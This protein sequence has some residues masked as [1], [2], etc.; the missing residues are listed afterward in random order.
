MYKGYEIKYTDPGFWQIFSFRFLSG[1]PFTPGGLRFWYSRGGRLGKCG[2]QA[3][4]LDGGG[5]GRRHIDLADY[6]ICGV[7]EDVAGRQYGFRFRLGTLYHRPR[8]FG[9]YDKREYGGC[10]LCLPLGTA[11]GRLWGHPGRSWIRQVDVTTG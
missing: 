2:T 10:F 8:P 4:W 7:V 9:Q 5:E 6:T 3:L 11:E 1:Q